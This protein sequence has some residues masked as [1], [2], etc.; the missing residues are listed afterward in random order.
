MCKAG[1]ICPQHCGKEAWTC[2]AAASSTS[3]IQPVE[4]IVSANLLCL[5][6]VLSVELFVIKN[7]GFWR[8]VIPQ[9]DQECLP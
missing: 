5:L 4:K 9:H 1:L 7:Y 3:P 2:K 6:R 8:L